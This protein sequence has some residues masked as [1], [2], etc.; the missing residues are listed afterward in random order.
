MQP[1]PEPSTARRLGQAIPFGFWVVG[2]LAAIVVVTGMAL[3][4]IT[5]AL[6]PIS[7][8]II[9]VTIALL[10]TALLQPV[11]TRLGRIGIKQSLG[12]ALTLVLFLVILVGAFWLTGA[13]IATGAQ[14]LV[15]GVSAA[16]DDIQAWLKTEPFGISGDQI[17]NWIEQG[18]NWLQTNWS[19]LA[20]GALRAGEALTSFTLILLLALVSTYFYLAQ[21]RRMWLFFVRLLPRRTHQPVHEAFRRG[22]I[23]VRAYARTQIIVAAVDAVGIGLGALV[24]GVPLV[25]PIAVLTFLMAFIPVVGAVLSGMVA[26]LIAFAAK[27]WVAALIMLGVVLAV[28]QIESNVLQPVL[29]SKAVDIHPW[30]VIVGVVVFSSF[31]GIMGALVS[32]PVMAMTKVVVLSLRGHDDYPDLAPDPVPPYGQDHPHPNGDT[33]EPLVDEEREVT[34]TRGRD[35]A[36]A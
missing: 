34:G 2:A 12:A 21:G 16:L 23:A 18:R 9:A 22:W 8:L 20:G 33:D 1:T 30:A 25:V 17:S 24:L 6:A 13:Q 3:S 15:D 7:S 26:V 11:V 4:T 14:D 32:V 27:G 28:Q 29:M 19:S 31:W 35:D 10:L 5:K 36:D